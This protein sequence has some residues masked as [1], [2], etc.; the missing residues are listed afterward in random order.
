METLLYIAFWAGLI[1]L[2]TRFGCGAHVPGHGH[3]HH[4][5]ATSDDEARDS[6]ALRWVPP[7]TDIDPVCGKTVHTDAAKPSVHDGLVYYLCSREC[8]EQ[9]EAAP[10][11]YVG[12]NADEQVGRL[13]HAHG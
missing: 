5:A 13:D 2:M 11:L 10:E 3:G 4:R 7:E 6:E 8:R 12:P 1:F 9:F